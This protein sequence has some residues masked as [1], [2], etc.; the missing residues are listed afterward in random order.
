MFGTGK[1]GSDSSELGSRGIGRSVVINIVSV[2][3]EWNLPLQAKQLTCKVFR[4]MLTKGS[5]KKIIGTIIS[6]EWSTNSTKLR[7]F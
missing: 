6:S 5:L 3:S 2:M 1:T 4:K 7:L